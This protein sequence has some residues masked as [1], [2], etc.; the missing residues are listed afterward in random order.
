MWD[1]PHEDED[2]D[3]EGSFVIETFKIKNKKHFNETQFNRE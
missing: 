2:E 3:D 1:Q